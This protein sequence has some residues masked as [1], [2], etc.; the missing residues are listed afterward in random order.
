[1]VIRISMAHTV[2][3]TE[4][5]DKYITENL[6]VCHNDGCCLQL[7]WLALHS[8]Q[9][10]LISFLRMYLLNA[11]VCNE[12]KNMKNIKNRTFKFNQHY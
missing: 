2:T 9:V 4:L 8:Y 5:F 7:W 6:S 3:M 1:M 11:V 10:L 12:I